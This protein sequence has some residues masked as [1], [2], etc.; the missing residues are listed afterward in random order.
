MHYRSTLKYLNQLNIPRFISCKGVVSFQLHGF[1][2]ALKAAYSACIYVRTEDQAGNVRT[3]LLCSKS[4]VAP[5][6][7]QTIPR[8]KLYGALLLVRLMMKTKNALKGQIDGI[9]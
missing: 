1:A 8:L 2:D 3:K 4:R 9:N 5:L 7:T 6:K